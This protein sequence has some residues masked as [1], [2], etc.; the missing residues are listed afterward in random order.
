MRSILDGLGMGLGFC[1]TLLL[2]GAVREVL[3]SGSLLGIELF[4]ADFQD[5]V[6]MVLP[7]GGFFTFAGWLL[8]FNWRKQRRAATAAAAARHAEGAR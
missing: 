3:G 2:L 7:S 6:I 4:G 1:L 5:W 8:F